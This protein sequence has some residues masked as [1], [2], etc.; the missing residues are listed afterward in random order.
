VD[1][2]RVMVLNGTYEIRTTLKKD[3]ATYNLTGK[4]VTATCRRKL[5]PGHILHADY[6]NIAVTLGNSDTT[7]ANGGVTF[8][9]TPDSTKGWTAPEDAEDYEDYFIQFYVSTD[10]YYPQLMQVGVRRQLD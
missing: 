5:T 8:N 9:L 2:L 3:G 4:T 6:E 10:D 7:T 1:S